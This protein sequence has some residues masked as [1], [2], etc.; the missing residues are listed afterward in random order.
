MSPDLHDLRLFAEGYRESV[1]V[2]RVLGYHIVPRSKALIGGL[3]QF[4]LVLAYRRLQAAKMGEVGAGWHCSQAP[5]AIGQL[6]NDL[7]ALID[8]P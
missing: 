7:R 3:L 6:A 5:D 2:L 1:A 4:M 8:T